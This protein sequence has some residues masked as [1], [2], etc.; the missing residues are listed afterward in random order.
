MKAT[1]L[2][3]MMLLAAAPAIAAPVP[4]VQAPA[5]S[6]TLRAGEPLIGETTRVAYAV[7]CPGTPPT[8]LSVTYQSSGAAGAPPTRSA[9]L[10]RPPSSRR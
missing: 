4:H 2:A 3:S 8:S 6:C 7:H 5:Q 9:R 10:E 1:F